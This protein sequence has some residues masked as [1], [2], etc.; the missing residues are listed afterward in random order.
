MDAWCSIPASMQR[1]SSIASCQRAA[2]MRPVRWPF[3]PRS[4]SCAASLPSFCQPLDGPL[5]QLLSFPII[6]SLDTMTAQPRC[7]RLALGP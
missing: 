2:V 1:A 3:E 4:G 7:F 5:L 6:R